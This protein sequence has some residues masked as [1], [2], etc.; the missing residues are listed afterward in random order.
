MNWP[1]VSERN[2]QLKTQHIK[3]EPGIQRYFIRVLG[4]QF[5][6]DAN[7]GEDPKCIGP[8]SGIEIDEMSMEYTCEK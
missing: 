2:L 7:T 6:K 5:K 4:K 3:V 8:I 1:F